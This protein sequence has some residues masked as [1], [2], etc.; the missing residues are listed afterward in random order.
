MQ[1]L[2]MLFEKDDGICTVTLNRP[3]ALNAI[4][5]RLASEILDIADKIDDDSSIRAVVIRG[6]GERAFSVG[7]DFKELIKATGGVQ[8]ISTLC[9]ISRRLLSH[10]PCERI[11]KLSKP[12]I[13]AVS[14]FA[15]GGGLELALACDIRLASE[16]ATFG[17]PEVRLGIIPG[18]GGT[19]RLPRIAGRA[20]ALEM[21]LTGDSINAQ[22]AYRT[23]LVISV[24]PRLELLNSSRELALKL[25]THAPIA[26][27]FARE[28]VCKGLDMTYDQG[29]GLETDLSVLLQTTE[30]RAEGI[31]SFL[32]K[33]TPRFSG[34]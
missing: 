34:R 1:Y 14:G 15:L 6:A 17:F 3:E 21:I 23:E 29:L 12:T 11:A 2:R 13:A 30:D 16:D 18:W 27:R 8:D 31:R 19:Q 26:A 5:R 9:E 10:N 24:V 33:R 4:D 7:M 32:E 28:A 22:E 20:K 25:A